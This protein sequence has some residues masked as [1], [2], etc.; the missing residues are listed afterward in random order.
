MTDQEEDKTFNEAFRFLVE[1][2]AR[3]RSYELLERLEH[4]DYRNKHRRRDARK[5]KDRP[6]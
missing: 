1:N 2:S 4:L 6:D 5:D 3:L